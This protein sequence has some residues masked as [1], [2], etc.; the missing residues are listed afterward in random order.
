VAKIIPK[1]GEPLFTQEVYSYGLLK[2]SFQPGEEE[3]KLRQLVRHRANLVRWG[4]THAQQMQKALAQMNLQLNNVVSDILG[5][6]G[7]KI[8]RAICLGA[9]NPKTL[10]RFRDARCKNSQEVIEKSLYGHYR[11]EILFSLKQ[12]LPS[13]DHYQK[14]IV[15]CNQEIEAMTH[16]FRDKSGGQIISKKKENKKIILDLMLKNNL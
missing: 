16:N 15:E 1:T 7:M 11:E 5:E 9:K 2:P 10:S 12:A 14:Q 3:N 8:I 13:Y 4:S 6:T